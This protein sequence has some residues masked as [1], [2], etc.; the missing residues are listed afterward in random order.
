M[1][2]GRYAVIDQNNV[3]T[4]VVAWDGVSLYNPGDGL[5]LVPINEGASYGPG[6]I[7]DPATQTF[8]DP[9]PPAPEPTP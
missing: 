2:S 3:L 6:W 7:Y 8:I 9:N 4:N 5:T 1:S